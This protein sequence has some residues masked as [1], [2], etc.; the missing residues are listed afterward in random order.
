VRRGELPIKSAWIVDAGARSKPD[1][2]KQ[3]CCT[4]A[5]IC[6]GAGTDVKNRSIWFDNNFD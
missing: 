2:A 5:R 6:R 1:F 3:Q 4:A